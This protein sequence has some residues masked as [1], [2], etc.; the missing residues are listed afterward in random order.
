MFENLKSKWFKRI[1]YV[2]LINYCLNFLLLCILTAC[3]AM[4]LYNSFSFQSF[5]IYQEFISVDYA[6]FISGLFQ[7]MN[8]YTA[9]VDTNQVQLSLF[10]VLLVCFF[11]IMV[12]HEVDRFFLHS[13]GSSFVNLATSTA[14]T[15]DAS[16]VVY[17][18]YSTSCPWPLLNTSSSKNV[19][20][21]V[22]NTSTQYPLILNLNDAVN[23]INLGL[24][25]SKWSLGAGVTRCVVFFF[26][27][28][29]VGYLSFYAIQDMRFDQ[30]RNFGAS[31]EKKNI[32]ERYLAII[33]G[34]KSKLTACA[35]TILFM[36]SLKVE[37]YYFDLGFDPTIFLIFVPIS[38]FL[39]LFMI[40]RPFTNR[41]WIAVIFLNGMADL[42]INIYAVYVFSST[43]LQPFIKPYTYLYTTVGI[44]ILTKQLIDC[45][46]LF[47]NFPILQGLLDL[48]SGKVQHEARW[49]LE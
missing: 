19:T 11:G 12:S 44:L 7:L 20:V 28:I 17:S 9:L 18:S 23:Q 47:K 2:A 37:S 36:S 45:M 30:Y 13:C 33:S 14:N 27:T 16:I 46:V 32:Y 39:G 21:T 1:V 43:R 35:L 41:F 25:Y 5:N 24:E 22:S 31:I 34:I 6:F 4:Y 10:Y 49:V 42:A 15:T 29:I 3:S 26:Y 40:S 8:I 38:M 48:K